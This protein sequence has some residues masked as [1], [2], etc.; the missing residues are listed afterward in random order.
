MR[1]SAIRN[2]MIE[3]SQDIDWYPG[4][5]RGGIFGRWLANTR[6][7]SISRNRF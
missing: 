1:A 2:R 3:F 4:Y 7:W 6:D 5:I